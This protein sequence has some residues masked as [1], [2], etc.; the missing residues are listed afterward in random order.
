MI[1]AHFAEINELEKIYTPYEIVVHPTYRA[2][3]VSVN[4]LRYNLE[5]FERDT[6]CVDYK[7]KTRIYED[8]AGSIHMFKRL[9]FKQTGERFYYNFWNRNN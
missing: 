6:N 4:L 2:S 8:N 9:G 5:S 1:G 7:I 3:F